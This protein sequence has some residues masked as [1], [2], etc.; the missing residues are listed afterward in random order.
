L[1]PASN[2]QPDLETKRRDGEEGIG[3]EEIGEGGFER[4]LIA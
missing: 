4:I 2:I 1:I 3:K